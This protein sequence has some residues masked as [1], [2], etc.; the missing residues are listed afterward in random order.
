MYLRIIMY[1]LLII[2]IKIEVKGVFD[3]WQVVK[4]CYA[5]NFLTQYLIQRQ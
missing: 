2:K 3:V 4:R 1:L 5:T